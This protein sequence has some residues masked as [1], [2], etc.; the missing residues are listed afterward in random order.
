[1]ENP[2][3]QIAMFT[4]KIANW[5]QRINK[6]TRYAPYHTIDSRGQFSSDEILYEDFGGE[7]SIEVFIDKLEREYTS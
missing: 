2:T 3:E 4:E 6:F 5:R 7:D 1:M